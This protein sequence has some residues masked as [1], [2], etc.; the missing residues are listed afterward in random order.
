M[1]YRLHMSLLLLA[2]TT[3]SCTPLTRLGQNAD[4]IDNNTEFVHFLSPDELNAQILQSSVSA[5]RATTEK[6]SELESR[7][8]LLRQ[9]V[10]N[11]LDRSNLLRGVVKSN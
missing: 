8:R 1:K 5:P 10:L 6:V 9:P 7:A 2:M 4:Q 3:A 11:V